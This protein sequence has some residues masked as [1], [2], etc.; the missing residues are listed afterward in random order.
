MTESEP[1]GGPGHD[2]TKI[3]VK[4]KDAKESPA[5]D[6]KEETE[7]AKAASVANYG[8]CI[9]LLTHMKGLGLT[10]CNAKR[11]LSYGMKHGGIVIMPLALICAMGSGVVCE[12]GVL[13]SFG[14]N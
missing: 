1:E 11:V 4:V 6:G 10:Q 3:K 5:K 14:S 9:W 12:S 7:I 2:K 13:H 8:V